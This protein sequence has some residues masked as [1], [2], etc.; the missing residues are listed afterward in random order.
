ME[1]IMSEDKEKKEEPKYDIEELISK[2]G[3]EL[4]TT[5]KNLF[6]YFE[7]CPTRRERWDMEYDKYLAFYNEFNVK[8]K[9]AKEYEKL[10]VP[11]FKQLEEDK[12]EYAGPVKTV[13]LDGFMHAYLYNDMH[14]EE[15]KEERDKYEAR[16]EKYN[17][18]LTELGD[19]T[20]GHGKITVSDPCYE[21]DAE[22]R[23]DMVSLDN[24]KNGTW[25]GF[26]YM[27]EN[28]GLRNA[29]LFAFHEKHVDRYMMPHD[30]TTVWSPKDIKG[31]VHIDEQHV[32]VDSGQAGIFDAFYYYK[33]MAVEGVELVDGRYSYK[34]EKGWYD[35][36]CN[37]TL[38]RDTCA[39]VINTGVVSSS[40]WGDGGY[41]CW[42]YMEEGKVVGVLIDYGL[43]YKEE[44]EEAEES[45][46][47]L[48]I[49]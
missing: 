46:E 4:Y 5:F 39:G 2:V 47:V 9:E 23:S 49:H 22:T 37:Q 27:H 12:D 14:L 29:L 48:D 17:D 31:W 18:K 20:I 7:K 19:F 41:G 34:D 42:F 28:W 24:A 30:G 26:T 6:H 38:N 13:F 25:K 33:D 21:Y 35:V 11:I 32:G 36:I 15:E 40:G 1:K 10:I 44:E 45:E 3:D 8:L 16:L 43:M